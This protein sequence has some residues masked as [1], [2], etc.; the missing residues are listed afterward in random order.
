MARR[1]LTTILLAAVWLLYAPAAESG[2]LRVL[3]YNIHHGAGSDG[4][5]DLSRIASVIADANPDI[6]SLQEVDNGVPRTGDVDQVARLAQ[7]T[8]M[9]SYFAK[10]RNLNGGA[11]GNGILIRQGIDIVSNQNFALPNPDNTE[12]RVVA[13]LGLSFDSNPATAEFNFFAT[14]LA[15]DSPAGRQQSATFINGLVSSSTVPSILAGDMNFNP[16]STAFNIMDNQWIDA[17]NV[18]NSGKNRANQ[19]DYVFYRQSPQWTVTTGG[20]FILNATTNVASDHDPLLAVLDLKSVW[21]GNNLVW[22]NNTGVATAVTDGFATGNS[23]GSVGD[24]PASPWNTAF[25][26]GTQNLLIGYNGNATLSGSSTR[27]IGSLRI[28]TNQANATI[29]GRNGNGMLSVSGSLGLKV[30]DSTEST[31]DLIVGEGSQAGTLNWNGSGTLEVQGRLRVGQGGTGTMNQAGGVVI[32]GNVAGSTK[33]LGIGVDPG[34]NGTYNLDGG[35]LRPSGGFN[36][37]QFRQT[38]VGDNSA[39]GVLNVGND[40]GNAASA[41]IESNDDLIV[42]RGGGNGTLRVRND[43]RI[44][45]RSNPS[46]TQ[47]ELIV[48]ESG[49]GTVVQ[50]GGAVTSDALVRIGGGNTGVGSYIMSGGTLD[51]ATDGVAPFQ[52]A[53][54][55]ASGTLRISGSAS[56]THGAEMIIADDTNTGSNGRLELVGSQ[57]SFR[58]GQLENVSGGTNGMRETISW[59]ADA[60]GVTSI[61][62]TGAGALTSNRVRLQSAAEVAANT[63][64]G[65]LLTGDGVALMLDLAAVTTSR[66]LTLIDNQTTD[67][68]QGFFESSATTSLYAEGAPILGTGFNGSVNISYLGGS[69]NDVVL[70]LVAAP[71]IG[72]HN[73]DGVV[74]A[75]DYVVWRNNPEATFQGY[76]DWRANFGN[77]QGQGGSATA[78]PE[79]SAGTALLLLALLLRRPVTCRHSKQTK[80]LAAT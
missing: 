23:S 62:V 49:Q 77:S 59:Q 54:G 27:N 35:T 66:T 14:H 39:T 80:R 29:V 61:V 76:L 15:H 55:G 50:T 67:P 65:S 18:A 26:N 5:L 75:A 30:N 57:A 56:V 12:P 68:I 64:S 73:A 11:Y 52:I 16:G 37:T 60:G 10:A 22:N 74:D 8:G 19:I 34:S 40:V 33:F 63:G 45:L 21:P 9:Q 70:S 1:A 48:G 43:G 78:V 25:D 47:A 4:V 17:T 41:A 20:Q 51:T 71:I 42:G 3:T 38:L 36:G 28:G 79:P 24:F 2:T 72:D 32:A 44:E 6:V 46:S 69:G 58:I 7:L 31:G 13:Q 53:R